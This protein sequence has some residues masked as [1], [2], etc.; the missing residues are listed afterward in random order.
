M[1][2]SNPPARW[3]PCA[4][5]KRI[6]GLRRLEKTLKFLR[7]IHVFD[8]VL[9]YGSDINEGNWSQLLFYSFVLMGVVASVIEMSLFQLCFGFD[10]EVFSYCTL[11]ETFAIGFQK[12][13]DHEWIYSGVFCSKMASFVEFISVRTEIWKNCSIVIFFWRHQFFF[14]V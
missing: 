9:K 1:E 12:C 6:S 10:I 11:T 7:C 2:P 4:C 13:F 5:L 8:L 14:D 3:W